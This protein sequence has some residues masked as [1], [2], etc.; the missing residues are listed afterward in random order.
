MDIPIIV[1]CY[2]NYKYIKNTLE[3]ILR[4]NKEYYR[5][6]IILNNN[7]TCLNTINYLD[8][9]DV[10]VIHNSSN[11]GPWISENKNQHIYVTL[12]DKFI[13]TDPDLQ[14]NENIP[15]NFIQILSELSDKYQTSKIGFALDL[16]DSD[17]FYNMPKYDEFNGSIYEWEIQFWRNKINDNKYELYQHDIDTTFCL[18]NKHQLYRNYAI[19]VAGNFTAK[20]IP[21]YIEN[22]IYNRYE[23]Y[24]TSKATTKIS[25]I[26]S[27][28][29][30][31]V[32]KN[33]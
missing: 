10:K 27:T 9:V 1:V 26:S 23:N 4:I 11:N 21:W 15:S 22:T 7:S 30:S 14:L 2:N 5:N 28:I 6:I 3:Q 31:Y 32:D 25:T 20:H 13:L 29:I 33:L 16:S 18:I 24:I 19:R 12:P 17:K 8:T